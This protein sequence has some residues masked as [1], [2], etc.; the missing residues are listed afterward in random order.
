M[1]DPSL[2]TKPLER[3]YDPRCR[4]SECIC[5]CCCDDCC[6]CCWLLRADCA[7]CSCCNCWGLKAWFCIWNRCCPPMLTFWPLPLLTWP[8]ATFS[9]W[10]S[11]RNASFSA[12]SHTEPSQFQEHQLFYLTFDHY[13]TTIDQVP[14]SL[15]TISLVPKNLYIEMK[16]L[17]LH[18]LLLL[19]QFSIQNRP[20]A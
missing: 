14:N 4:K 13:M 16:M 15:Y 7:C 20:W 18:P 6:G 19:S 3:L 9:R 17:E 5:C 11:S 1:V 2:L 10:T 12:V 8:V